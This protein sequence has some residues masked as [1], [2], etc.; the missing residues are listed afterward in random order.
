MSSPSPLVATVATK[1]ASELGLPQPNSL[2]ASNLIALARSL[3]TEQAFVKA[4]QGFG[5]FGEAFLGD[6]RH[7]VRQSNQDATPASSSSSVVGSGSNGTTS[8]N[9]HTLEP[10]QQ[11]RVGLRVMGDTEV[12]GS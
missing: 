10:P 12:S 7:E 4:A 8:G 1:V 2:L 5:R 3:P 6:I 11:M 9:G